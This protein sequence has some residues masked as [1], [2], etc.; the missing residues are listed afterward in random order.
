[1]IR[2]SSC[3]VW[4][5]G[6]DTDEYAYQAISLVFEED[7]LSLVLDFFCQPDIFSSREDSVVSARPKRHGASEQGQSPSTEKREHTFHV[8][9]S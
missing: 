4:A 9:R 6:V 1:M 5:A 7:H 8:T 2:A 3:K